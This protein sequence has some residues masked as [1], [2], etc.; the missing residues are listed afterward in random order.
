MKLVFTESDAF[1]PTYDGI[2]VGINQEAVK[3][4]CL[5]QN[6]REFWTGFHK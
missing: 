2:N 4:L 6:M 3:D 1:I 5:A